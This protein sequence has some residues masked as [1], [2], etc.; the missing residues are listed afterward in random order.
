MTIAEKVE[1]ETLISSK[2]LGAKGSISQRKAEAIQG[3]NLPTAA[4]YPPEALKLPR[5]FLTAP[6]STAIYKLIA[7]EFK[8][9]PKK[10]VTNP[11]ISE[12]RAYTS[13]LLDVDLEAVRIEVVPD[14][15]WD[16]GDSIEGFQVAVGVTDHLV[17]VPES[18]SS[19]EELLCH[20][21]GHSGHVTAQRMNGELP[22]FDNLPTTAELVAHYVQFNYLLEHKDRAHFVA[23]LAQLTTASYALSIYASGIYDDFFS[24]LNSDLAAQIRKAMPIQTLQNFYAHFQANQQDRNH[25]AMR[26]IAIVL[27]LL[28]VDERDGMRR[29]IRADRIDHSLETKLRNAFPNLDLLLS[30][31]KI[32]ERIF[33][34][35]ERFRV[36]G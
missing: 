23:A 18:F 4:S 27:A 34:L 8:D 19:P 20:E 35:L 2:L 21:L 5:E 36:D 6:V 26:G 12:A 31:A 16:E 9:F 17:F 33:E 25:Q 14:S 10:R 22:Y 15:E 24:Y 32:N 1:L 28:L 30:F 11:M 13:A 29:F 7:T 3:I